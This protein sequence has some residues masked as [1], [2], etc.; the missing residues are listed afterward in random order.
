[1]GLKKYKLLASS[2]SVTHSHTHIHSHSLKVVVFCGYFLSGWNS[3]PHRGIR[4]AHSVVQRPHTLRRTP[5]L[6]LMSG[7][8]K[9][10]PQLIFFFYVLDKQ[11]TIFDVS[12]QHARITFFNSQSG[13]YK[14]DTFRNYLQALQTVWM[15]LAKGYEVSQWC[16][17]RWFRPL[18]DS[19]FSHIWS[20][21]L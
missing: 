6:T 8:L 1:M 19:S 2:L 16:T 20:V 9:L 13:D 11:T 14:K 4:S 21:F 15:V 7:F 17:G 3:K 12:R 10:F 18:T 5:H